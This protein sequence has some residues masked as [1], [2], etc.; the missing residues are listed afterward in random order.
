MGVPKEIKLNESRVAITPEGV[1]ELRDKGVEVY[2]ERNA[3]VGASLS[4]AMYEQAGAIL[5]DAATAWSCDLVVKVKEP[6]ASEFMYFRKDLILFTFL[7]LAA[8]P[9]VAAALNAA[10]TTG[11]AY[12]TVEVDHGLP[13]LAPMSEIAGR[14]SVQIASRFLEKPQGGRG[15]LLSGAPGVPPARVT[16]LGAGNVGLNA[17][18]LAS[19]LGAQVE[20]FDINLEKLRTIDLM[21]RTRFTTRASSH[22][23]IAA[24]VQHADAVIGGVLVPGG[25]APVV[26]DAHMIESMKPGSVVIDCAIDQGGCIETTHETTHAEPVFLV[27]DVVHYAVG[28]MPGAVPFTSTYALT[29]ATLPFI[30]AL[31]THSLD[32]AREH[33]PGLAKGINTR[34]GH[35]VNDS[36]ATAVASVNNA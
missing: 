24:S 17:A 21:F 14:L 9:E 12:E 7:H 30:V 18:L 13:L 22:A 6:Q 27:N 20:L 34:G 26:V 1:V 35:T 29:N 36:V 3:G 11:I 25:R 31:G 23:A 15:I 10:G 8:Y 2:V 28:N 4:D 19:S 5:C 16:V 33:V 32:D